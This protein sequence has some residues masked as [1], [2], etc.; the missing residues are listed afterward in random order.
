MKMLIGEEVK[1]YCMNKNG[2]ASWNRAILVNDNHQVKLIDSGLFRNALRVI[3][4]K[5]AKLIG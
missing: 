4:S 2:V 3:A 5:E 1:A